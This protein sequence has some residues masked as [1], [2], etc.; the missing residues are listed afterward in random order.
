SAVLAGPDE[1]TIAIASAHLWES[2]GVPWLLTAWAAS[3][4]ALQ[5]ASDATLWWRQSGASL[6]TTL[7]GST[8]TVLSSG[9]RQ[10]GWGMP[11][12]AAPG[13][14]LRR[15]RDATLWARQS[16]ASRGT[17]VRGSATTVLS[18][19]NRQEGWVMGAEVLPA[20]H[21]LTMS[22]GL[23]MSTAGGGRGAVFLDH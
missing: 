16:G 12:W 3:G 10:E 13:P 20:L 11:A 23:T 7:R 2:G 1:I 19:G 9:N 5:R 8:T 21:P 14:A 6:G 17:T 4:P 18:S 15:A 22:V